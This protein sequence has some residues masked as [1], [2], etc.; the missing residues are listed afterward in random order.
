[1]S[2]KTAPVGGVIDSPGQS[3]RGSLDRRDAIG[4]VNECASLCV[5]DKTNNQV[6]TGGYTHIRNVLKGRWGY[7]FLFANPL[8]KSFNGHFGT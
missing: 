1:M 2:T 4:H 5:V 8:R 6:T 3:A 7:L